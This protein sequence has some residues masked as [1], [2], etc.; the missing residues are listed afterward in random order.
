MKR[1]QIKYVQVISTEDTIGRYGRH[2]FAKVAFENKICITQNISLPRNEF[3][4]ESDTDDAIDKLSL[5]DETTVV[6][7]FVTNPRLLL[8]SAEKKYNITS[9]YLFIAT[10][11]WGAN[12]DMLRDLKKLLSKRQI[13]IFDVETADLPDFDKYLDTESTRT[14]NNNWFNEYYEELYRCTTTSNSSSRFPNACIGTSYR[15]LPIAP[16]YIQDPYVLFVVNA[17]FAAAVGIHGALQEVCG[18]NYNIICERFMSS[19]QRP[20]IQRNILSSQFI[21]PGLQPFYYME[22]GNDN[23]RGYHIYEPVAAKYYSNVSD[24]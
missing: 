13:V 4:T 17:V 23:I 3:L 21:D 11:K 8:L 15:T 14:N 1:Y 24:S 2:E 12:P 20:V 9:H 16:D 6:V 22:G 18:P 19:D 5:Q 10:D 7:L